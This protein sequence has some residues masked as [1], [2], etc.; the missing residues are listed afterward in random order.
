MEALP[1]RL[2]GGRRE[3]GKSNLQSAR[4]RGIRDG[5]A[6]ASCRRSWSC[7]SSRSS[8]RATAELVDESAAIDR[9][10]TELSAVC[11]EWPDT[12]LR[13]LAIERGAPLRTEA[14]LRG[15]WRREGGPPS[16]SPEATVAS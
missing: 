10:L 14:A 13:P 5:L 4:S 8:L 3:A 1:T 9:M 2:M 15:R 7:R 11:P 6:C 16:I 12:P